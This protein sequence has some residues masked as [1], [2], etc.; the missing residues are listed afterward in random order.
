MSQLYIKFLRERVEFP[1]SPVVD[2]VLGQKPGLNYL[3][4]SF[5]LVDV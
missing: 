5:N 2:T 3:I 4:L 1:G